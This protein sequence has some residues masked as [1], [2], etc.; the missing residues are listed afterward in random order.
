MSLNSKYTSANMA[1]VNNHLCVWCMSRNAMIAA[2]PPNRTA[3]TPGSCGL[4][5]NQT[6]TRTEMI[7]ASK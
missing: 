4:N 3:A 2:M 7:E 6:E 5:H 1:P